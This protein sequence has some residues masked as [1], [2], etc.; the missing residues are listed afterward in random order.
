MIDSILKLPIRT[1]CLIHRLSTRIEADKSDLVLNDM[2]VIV[3]L[4]FIS[5]Y[6]THKRALCDEVNVSEGLQMNVVEIMKIALRPFSF[7]VERM[8]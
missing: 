3:I 5:R 6:N 7:L 1:C 8:V 4:Q 2:M